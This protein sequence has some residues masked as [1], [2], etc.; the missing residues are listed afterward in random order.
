VDAPSS[1][2]APAAVATCPACGASIA[3]PASRFCGRCGAA[4]N[5]TP[6]PP[7]PGAG[8]APAPP[9]G[10]APV[11]IRARVEA[12]RGYLKRLQ[13]L[14]PGF[15]GYRLGEDARAADSF[16]RLQVADRVHRSVQ[17]LQDCRNLLTRQNQYS[18]L[19]DL[20]SLLSDLQQ[21][22]SRIRFA[23][24]G[25]SGLAPALRVTP[26]MLDRLYEYDYGFVSAA[27]QLLASTGAVVQAATAGNAAGLG[28]ALQTV[29]GQVGQLTN[30]FQARMREI[31]GIQA[32]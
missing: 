21:L 10:P 9:A 18:A 29:H 26:E 14:L 5:G 30:A 11:D 24:Q 20:A 7:P 12:D 19:T 17:A 8:S 22:E 16:L 6:P 1:P 15:R 13:L 25:Y 27:D 4:L 3:D 32:P 28:P 31:E 23:E 2:A